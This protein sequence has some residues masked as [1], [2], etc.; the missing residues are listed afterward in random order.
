MMRRCC[1][2]VMVLLLPAFARADLADDIKTILRDKYLS[3]VQIGIS[4][5]K[6]G[7]TPETTVSV[8]RSDADI[9]LIP[10]SNL[11]LLT[12]SAFLDR[13][14]GDFKFHTTLLAKD[15]DL[16]L[17][18]D[19]DPTLGDADLL[20]KL[21]WDV[22]T[23]FKA[24]AAELTKRGVTTV[25]NVI[26]DDSVFDQQFV[27]Q[28]WLARNANDKYAAQIGGVN[29]NANCV[30]FWVKTTTP[31]Q[32][33]SY[34]LDPPTHYVTV[35]NTCLT[36]TSNTV[37]VVR[38]AGKNDLQLRGEVKT[39]LGQPASVPVQDPP[40]FAATV[41]AETLAAN[42]I[43]VT[44]KVSRDLTVRQKYA[45]DQ[46]G[47]ALV[48]ALET[49]LP[50]VL[51]RANKESVNLYAECMCKRL[52]HEV[53]GQSGSWD[54]GTAA[55]GAFLTRIGIPATEFHLDDGC[56][57]SREDNVSADAL[58]KVLCYDFQSRNKETMFNSLA[59]PGEEG[60]FKTRFKKLHGRLVGKSGY[61]D[62]VSAV[63]GYLKGRDDNWYAFSILLNNC[64][65]KTN[66]VAKEIQEKIVMAVDANSRR[67]E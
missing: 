25:R 31:G 61:I 57:L 55:V 65:Y 3:K 4:I 33:A 28:H 24:W 64:P 50:T 45:H 32:L 47:W 43:D 48:A 11:K 54:N 1:F 13:V 53:T 21:G 41:L 23:V 56:G 42:G 62:N 27:P 10:A 12:T 66:D 44:G 26:V 2:L 38:Q 16:Y 14:G 6:I 17:I 60:T 34:F 63:S 51:G 67:G 19:G 37:A 58:V 52:G 9:P 15:G 8:Y 5:A 39:D 36:G 18:G 7:A 40:L 49:K 20:R 59:V 30:D 35:R 29:L 22:T 46:A